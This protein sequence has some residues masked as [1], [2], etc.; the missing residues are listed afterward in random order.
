LILAIDGR[1]ARSC[2]EHCKKYAAL[3]ILIMLDL[4]ECHFPE[5]IWTKLTKKFE[6]N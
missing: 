1:I 4:F 5:I 2:N 3:V 6:M